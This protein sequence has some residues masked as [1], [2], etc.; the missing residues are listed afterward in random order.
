MH[1]IISNAN[2]NLNLNLKSVRSVWNNFWCL[3]EK[4][5]LFLQILQ[6]F[7]FHICGIIWEVNRSICILLIKNQLDVVFLY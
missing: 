4:H 1:F 6:M 5:G 2:W 3:G 7:V